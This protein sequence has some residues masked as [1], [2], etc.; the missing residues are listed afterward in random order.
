V[1]LVFALAFEAQLMV[2][3]LPLRTRSVLLTASLVLLAVPL[4]GLLFWADRMEREHLN[5]RQEAS[6]RVEAERKRLNAV[7]DEEIAS[8]TRA[9][10]EASL[11]HVGPVALD[12]DVQTF[13]DLRSV[14][15]AE[16]EKRVPPNVSWFEVH[17]FIPDLASLDKS[18]SV[19]DPGRITAIQGLVIAYFNRSASHPMWMEIRE[20]FSGS[21]K[22]VRLSDT[23]A[24]VRARIAQVKR[25]YPPHHLASSVDRIA[26]RWSI[27]LSERDERLTRI[28]IEDLDY[29]VTTS[30]R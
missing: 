22:G 24:T 13:E 29:I 16:G 23:P 15:K 5:A 21:L 12:P 3:D 25:R 26:P 17:W 19:S 9:V 18:C 20:P 28:R 2:S 4:F 14:L 1:L 8:R 27:S 6:R 11:Q 7:C 30:L 10:L